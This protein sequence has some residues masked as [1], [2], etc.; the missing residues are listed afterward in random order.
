V[1]HEGTFKAFGDDVDHRGLPRDLGKFLGTISSIERNIQNFT[2]IGLDAKLKSRPKVRITLKMS[3][4]SFDF[5][6]APKS[7]ALKFTY[8]AVC[9]RYL[10][11]L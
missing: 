9:V 11:K 8:D 5:I 1:S 2:P 4:D 7:V 10:G 6:T 3:G